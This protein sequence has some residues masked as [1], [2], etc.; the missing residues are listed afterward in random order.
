MFMYID[1]SN[2]KD[3]GQLGILASNDGTSIFVEEYT[4]GAGESIELKEITASG[5]GGKGIAIEGGSDISVNSAVVNGNALA[6][7]S[8][9]IADKIDLKNVKAEGNYRGIVIDNSHEINLKEIDA[10]ANGDSGIF[11]YGSQNIQ[12]KEIRG[13]GNIE[14]GIWIE[15]SDGI[16]V[17]NINTVVTGNDFSGIFLG[18][19]KNIDLKNIMANGNGDAGIKIGG[20]SNMENMENI[21]ANNNRFGI[22]MV[23]VGSY[24]YGRDFEMSW[25]RRISLDGNNDKM[26]SNF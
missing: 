23:D 24:G 25:K 26:D 12:L 18:D 19:S 8:I 11:I 15:T 22:L 16:S 10:N 7:I 6:G 17:I 21:E 13:S 4:P 9:G 5:N 20:A 14:Y 2:A 1:C 3:N